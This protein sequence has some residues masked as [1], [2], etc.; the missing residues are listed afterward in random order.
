MEL[1]AEVFDVPAL[2]REVS[3]TI[4]PWPSAAAT[5]W[6][7][8]AARTCAGCAGRPSPRVRQVLLN[9]MSNAAK[10]HGERPA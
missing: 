9:L 4:G 8:A 5:R 1:F 6:S 2:V 7:C 10:V 3:G